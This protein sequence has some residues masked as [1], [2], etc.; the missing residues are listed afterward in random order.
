MVT[1]DGAAVGGELIN[2]VDYVCFTGSTRTGRIVAA[3][4]AERLIGCSLELGGKNPLLVLDDADPHRAAEGAVRACFS[5]AGQLC[6]SAERLYVDEAVL[7]AF[8]AAFVARTEALQL[9][10]STSFDDDVGR[11][12]Q[13]R[14][15]GP[16]QRAR[17]GRPRHGATVL[18]GGRTRPDIGP[19]FYEPTVLTGVTA[20]MRCATEETFGPVVSI[21]PVRARPRRSPRPTTPSTASTAASGPPTRCAVGGWPHCFAAAP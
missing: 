15:A 4:C 1:G 6:V 16:G 11:P 21:Y 19:L 9:G 7:P 8:T 10:S 17:R 13:R 20:Q 12:D 2:T 3:Q 5:N 14:P 18:A